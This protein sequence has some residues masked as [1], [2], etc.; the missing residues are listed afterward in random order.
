MSWRRF[1]ISALAA[2]CILA[3]WDVAA[4]GPASLDPVAVTPSMPNSACLDC[5]GKQGFAVP[6]GSDGQAPKRHLFVN[7]DALAASAHSKVPCVG[8]HADIKELPHAKDVKRGVDCIQCHADTAKAENTGPEKQ[9]IGNVMHQ[10]GD[11]LASIHAQPRKDDPSRPNATCVDCHSAHNV[12]PANTKAGADFRLSTPEVCGRCHAEQKAK[13]DASVHAAAVYRFADA[14]SATC[15]DCHTAHRISKAKEDPARLLITRNCGNCH[16]EAYKSYRATYHGQINVLGYT[17]TAKC[18]DCHEFHDTRK[19]SDPDSKVASANRVATCKQCHK[20][21]TAGFLGFRPHGNT[22]DF[23]KYPEMWITSKFMILLL[24]GVF[25]VFWSHSVLWFWR[26]WQDRKAGIRHVLVDSS[27]R[28]VEI[29]PLATNYSGKHIRRFNA[30]W[31][32]AHL[33]LA[34]AVMVLVLTGTSLL[35]AQTF[36]A[37]L[38]IKAFGGPKIAGLV[39]RTAAVTFGILFFGHIAVAGWT[40]AVRDRAGFRWFGPSSLLPN[41]Q[42]FRDFFA[43]IKWFTGKGPRPT[44]DHWTYWEK[45]DYWAPFWGMAIIGLSGLS[46]WFPE[47][48]ARFLPG[49]IFNAATILHGEEAFLAAVFLFTVH[50]FNSHFRPSKLPQDVSMFTGTVPLHEFI[51]DHGIEYKKLIESG[52]LESMLIPPPGKGTERRAK[53]LGAVLISSGLIL[54]L[55]VL[56]GFWQQVLFG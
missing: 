46:L 19:V 29:P 43:M 3:V 44:F 4:A 25:A 38:V 1:Q 45:F 17:N 2:L 49:W 54:L 24:A 15:A 37:P 40:I 34:I 39:H 42:D 47:I 21:A 52:K 41:W 9:R 14:K 28:P 53:I 5:H 6:E 11:F 30:G 7:G 12:F 16:Q 48:A 23:S 13:Y 31:R 56:E 50:Y 32:I 36:W 55:L 26:E 20:A 33:T 27:G 35:Y 10:T 51:R 8:C 18:F 22:H